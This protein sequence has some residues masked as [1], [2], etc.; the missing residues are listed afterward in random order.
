M[1][2]DMVRD[3]NRTFTFNA[4]SS[5]T[6]GTTTD[7]EDG[8]VKMNIGVCADFNGVVTLLAHETSHG[9][10][11]F[12][13]LVP[14]DPEMPPEYILGLMTKS[15]QADPKVKQYVESYVKMHRQEEKSANHMAN[16]VISELRASDDKS[17]DNL[18]YESYYVGMPTV[19]ITRVPT[20][21]GVEQRYNI[22]Y[23]L[24]FSPRKPGYYEDNKFD[25]KKEVGR[26]F[27][28]L[29]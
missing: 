9:Y 28:D 5:E 29:D 21:S 27:F 17:F 7:D 16:I 26:K 14:I 8:N 6:K 1:Y 19:D 22:G 3:K 20:M 10:R 15:L 13:N 11:F 24:W 18:Q 25:I 23:E 4:T 2:K 12:S